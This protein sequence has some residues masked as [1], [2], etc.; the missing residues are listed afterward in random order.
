MSDQAGTFKAKS[1]IKAAD[2]EHRRK[3]NFN[4]GRYNSAVPNGKQQFQDLAKARERAKNAKWR[5]I[6]TLDQQLEQFDAII[7]SRCAKLI[8]AEN[9]EQ[10]NEEVIRIC[11][12]VNCKTVVKTK[13]MVTDEIHLNDHLE[14]NAIMSIETDLGEYIQQ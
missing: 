9:A 10:A 6:E 1:T 12:S 5:S 13:S 11:K 8:L 7:T 4:I 2:I 3:I 14:K